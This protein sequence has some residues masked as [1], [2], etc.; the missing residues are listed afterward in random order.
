RGLGKPGEALT[1]GPDEALVLRREAFRH[2]AFEPG[3]DGPSPSAPNEQEPIVRDADE[4]RG[5]HREER[6][7]VVAVVE[8]PEVGEE[9]DDL[10]LAEVAA[11]CRPVS[12]QSLGAKLLLVPLGVGAGGEEEHDLPGR[13]S[14]RVDE[15]THPARDVS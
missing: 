5:E 13:C 9:V 1:E 11:P 7:V 4:R 3:E 10:L 8:E 6:L 14:P 2:R 12:R 15:Y